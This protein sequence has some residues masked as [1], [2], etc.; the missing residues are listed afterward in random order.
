LGGRRLVAPKGASTR[1]TGDRVK[2]AL[3]SVLGSLG[4]ARVV[5]LYAGTGALGLEAL[6]RGATDVVLVEAA[7]PAL[8][9]L[10]ENVR[11][12]GCEAACTVVAAR[13]ERAI[14][15]LAKQG[16]FDLVIADPPWAE[17]EAATRALAALVGAGALAR[18]GT[19]VLEHAAEDTPSIAGLAVRD[20]RRYGD[21][22]LT[23]FERTLD[24]SMN[25]DAT[26][27]DA[28]VADATAT[29]V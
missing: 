17:L 2:E 14:D 25:P 20:R 19:V 4:G 10:R 26:V 22:G 8:V 16:P 18:E 6:S 28:T 9:A 23:L 13:V 27:A 7:S 12:L 21:T 29:D 1:P 3:F 24:D 5:D 15:R 11:A